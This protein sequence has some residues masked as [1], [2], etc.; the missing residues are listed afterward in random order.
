MPSDTRVVP[1]PGGG[2]IPPEASTDQPGS[3]AGGSAVTADASGSQGDGAQ[4]P[5][6]PFPT[7][8]SIGTS[9]FAPDSDNFREADTVRDATLNSLQLQGRSTLDALRSNNGL[10]TNGRVGQL[11]DALS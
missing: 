7:T 6:S 5:P 11:Y 8:K 3:P 9:L 1:G 4:P 10:L 2:V